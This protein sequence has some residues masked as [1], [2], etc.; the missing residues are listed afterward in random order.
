MQWAFRLR[1]LVRHGSGG[2]CTPATAVQPLCSGIGAKVVDVNRAVRPPVSLEYAC[3]AS[4]M[5][6]SGVSTKSTHVNCAALPSASLDHACFASSV[7]CSG[8]SGRIVDV[9]CGT[10]ATFATTADGH[11]FTFG[12]NNYG[13]LA[14]PGEELRPL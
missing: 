6:C 13:Q 5:Y 9:N 12:L 4:S 7:R 3:F 14:L 1:C 11:V 2:F 8:V 10:Y